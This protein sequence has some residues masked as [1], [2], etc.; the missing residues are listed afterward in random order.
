MKTRTDDFVKNKR[1]LLTEEQETELFLKWYEAKKEGRKRDSEKYIQQIIIQ[2]TPLIRSTAKK[3]AGYNIDHE[4]LV[5]EGLLA[6]VEAANRFDLSKG[7]RFST[8]ARSW[9]KGVLFA[10]VT[11]NYFIT[12]VCTNAVNK[13]LF[14]SMRRVIANEMKENGNFE[15]NRQ[16]IGKLATQFETTEEEIITM[17][18]MLMSPY[19]SLN[20]PCSKD[21]ENEATKIDFLADDRPTPDDVTQGD[22]LS[23]IQKELI[24]EAMSML[25]D[26]ER[27]IFNAQVMI[28]E[29]KDI[30]TLEVLGERFSISKE[31][32]RQIRNHANV[33][34]EKYLHEIVRERG[35][36]P[37]ELF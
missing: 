24:D 17:N 16:M 5:S 30:Q 32:V 25:T 10:F 3:L 6:L 20:E 22:S 33:K 12:N 19:E 14:F 23:V 26:R 21:E 4:E 29:K 37:K 18:T 31:R 28:D 34:L 7:F 1:V 2:F 15:M 8:Y 35:I 9:I 13:K 36:R 27:V 11:K